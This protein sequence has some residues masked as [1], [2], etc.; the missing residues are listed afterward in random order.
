MRSSAARRSL[1]PVR[2]VLDVE[3]TPTTICGEL[4]ADGGERR[5]F[6]GWMELVRLIEACAPDQQ[7]SAEQ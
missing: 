3:L 6:R 2:F 5:P 4:T 1:R 7:R